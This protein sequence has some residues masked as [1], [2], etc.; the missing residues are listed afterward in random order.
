MRPLQLTLQAF[1]PFID[2]QTVDFQ[3]LESGLFLISG[4][5]GSGKTTIFDA[6]SF[7]LFGQASGTWR[8]Q[9]NLRSDQAGPDR[10]TFVRLEFSQQGKIY[11]IE[12]SPSYERAK[13]V[14]SGT[15]NQPAQQVLSLPDGRILT[16]QEDIDEQ[17]RS[18]LGIGVDQ[19]R[20]VSMLAQGEF[21]SF[22]QAGSQE[23]SDILRRIFQTDQLQVFQ[24]RLKEAFQEAKGQL[25]EVRAQARIVLEGL[26]FV[27]PDLLEAWQDLRNQG[28]EE[29]WDVSL[30]LG[31]LAQEKERDAAQ[32]FV[33]AQELETLSDQQQKLALDLAQAKTILDLAARWA[34][35]Q[36]DLAAAEAACQ[37]IGQRE[38]GLARQLEFLNQMTARRPDFDQAKARLDQLCQAQED[39]Q[40]QYAK[41][42]LPRQAKLNRQRLAFQDQAEARQ[43]KAQEAQLIQASLDQYDKL[44]SLEDQVKQAQDGLEA[45]AKTFRQAQAQAEKSAQAWADWQAQEQDRLKDLA[46]QARLLAATLQD[47]QACPVC[48]SLH[49]PHPADGQTE[50]LSSLALQP[51][52]LTDPELLETQAQADAQLLASAQT[53]LNQLEQELEFIQAQLKT[54]REDL[55][56]AS[57]AE[58]EQV[59]AT[60]EQNQ[61]AWADQQAKLQAE[62]E[63]IQAQDQAYKAQMDSLAGQRAEAE[64]QWQKQ[65]DHILA[66]LKNFALK[67]LGEYENLGLDA[68]QIKAQLDQ[69]QKDRNRLQAL[70]LE[71]TAFQ[72]NWQVPAQLPDLA[73]M[74]ARYDS[75]SKAI[76]DLRASQANIQSRQGQN[77]RLE[78][79]LTQLG[80]ELAQLELE[81]SDRQEVS[82]AANGQ[83]K[84]GINRDFETFVQGYYFQGILEAANIRLGAMTG[85]RYHLVHAQNPVDRRRLA[86]LEMEVWDSYSGHTRELSTLSGG[87]SF[88]TAMALALGLSDVARASQG[89]LALETLFI[90]EG[91]GS[92]DRESLHQAVTTLLE[93]SSGSY[94]CGLISHVEE[95]K[96]LIPQRLDVHKTEQG[97]YI[98]N[99]LAK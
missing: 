72:K 6:L 22:L 85:Q 52:S 65:E 74:Q 76:E 81:V 78:A 99:N 94:L 54:R 37:D 42:F 79:Q 80:Q 17:M 71:A 8:K 2:Q 29:F 95:L 47:G 26:Q 5:T 41:D 50:A 13:K 67:S 84:G 21:S 61:R 35:L 93:L 30:P 91:F 59:L 43:A 32:L 90:D 96:E 97:S 20:Q 16:K 73:Q 53:K 68:A 51:E 4:P 46:H 12:R 45:E 89:G 62:E 24:N 28:Q 49:H 18:I 1:G 10:E 38:E 9:R 70:Q 25:Q 55:A 87:E 39:L 56:Y 86:G 88:Q 23:R 36:Q 75:L 11:C 31:L 69:V 15:T 60:W 3:S 33:N 57:R 64:S 66:L 40:A 98:V 63:Q 44:A 27:S 83:L 82:Q 14:G 7:A 92:L 19:F 77:S 48:G 34:K 58:A